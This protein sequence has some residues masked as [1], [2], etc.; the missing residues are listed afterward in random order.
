MRSIQTLRWRAIGVLGLCG[1]CMAAPATTAAASLQ[2]APTRMALTPGQSSE[3]LWLTNT[4]TAPMQVQV[5]VFDWTQANG[6][7]VLTPAIELQ[8]SPPMQRIDAGQAQLIRVVR[9]GSTAAATE[10]AYRVVVDELPQLSPDAKGMQFVLRYSIPLFVA[11][12]GEA[13]TP[14]VSARL[15][16][17][18]DGSA[19]VEVRNEGTAHAQLADVAIGDPARPRIL[20]PGLVGY[21]LPG[22]TMHWTLDTPQSVPAGTPLSAKLNGDPAQTLLPA[23]APAR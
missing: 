20:R 2:V 7:D 23:T 6:K 10:Q 18:S 19:G 1:L 13:G 17:M 14:A 8:A 15:K 12:H 16:P 21:V 3:A 4:G 22:Q 11:P 9:T 5:R